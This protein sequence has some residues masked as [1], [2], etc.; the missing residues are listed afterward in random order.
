M[1]KTVIKMLLWA[2][3]PFCLYNVLTTLQPEV[4][5]INAMCGAFIALVLIKFHKIEELIEDEWQQ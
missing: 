4:A 5:I 1:Y 3:I 2:T